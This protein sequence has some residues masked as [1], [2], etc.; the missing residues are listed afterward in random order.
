MPRKK[1]IPINRSAHRFEAQLFNRPT[2]DIEHSEDENDFQSGDTIDDIDRNLNKKHKISGSC[3]SS[4]WIPGCCSR[5]CTSKAKSIQTLVSDFESDA[6]YVHL[7]SFNIS[8]S[9][10]L[11]S[12][13]SLTLALL[14]SALLLMNSGATIAHFHFPALVGAALV[15]LKLSLCCY[16]SICRNSFSANLFVHI[17]APVPPALLVWCK[18]TRFTNFPWYGDSTI[19]SLNSNAFLSS[20]STMWK[21]GSREEVQSIAHELL[22]AGVETNL[23]QYQL[24][25][26]HWM[27]HKL[28]SRSSTTILQTIPLSGWVMITKLPDVYYSEVLKS[29]WKQTSPTAA[30]DSYSFPACVLADEMGIG[31]SLQVISLILLL[32]TR[33]ERGLFMEKIGL[34]EDSHIKITTFHL[35]RKNAMNGSSHRQRRRSAIIAE[36]GVLTPCICGRGE[37]EKDDVGWVNCSV[38]NRPRHLRCAGLST[39]TSEYQCLSCTS[40]YY[41]HHPIPSKTVLIIIPSTLTNQW[42]NEI[43]KH[44]NRNLSLKVGLYRGKKNPSDIAKLTPEFLSTFDIIFIS[45]KALRSCFYEAELDWT[46]TSNVSRRYDVF[47]PSLLGIEFRLVVIDETQNIEGATENMIFK[48][49][50]KLRTRR[51]LSVSG[52]PFGVGTIRDLLH[53]AQFLRISPLNGD[54]QLFNQWANFFEKPVLPISIETRVQWLREL[55]YPFILRRTKDMIR[56]QL[57]ISERFTLVRNLAMSEFEKKLYSDSVQAIHNEL[58]AKKLNDNFQALGK[59]KIELIRKACCHPRIF[60]PSLQIGKAGSASSI[61]KIMVM[62]VEQTKIRCEEAQRD[63]LFYLFK[64]AG[65]RLLQAQ[66]CSIW[67]ET[68]QYIYAAA[69]VYQLALR[70]IDKNRSSLTSF[71]LCQLVGDESFDE[72]HVVAPC[73]SSLL[74]TWTISEINFAVNNSLSENET[75]VKWSHSIPVDAQDKFILEMRDSNISTASISTDWFPSV[76]LGL[77]HKK[78]IISATISPESVWKIEEFCKQQLRMET[79]KQSLVVLFPAEYSLAASDFQDSFVTAV[80]YKTSS[81]L[82]YFSTSLDSIDRS[83]STILYQ[84]SRTFRAK[85][86]KINVSRCHSLVL[87]LQRDQNTITEH[88][89]W[90]FSWCPFNELNVCCRNPFSTTVKMWANF[91]ISETQFDTDML[92]ELHVQYNLRHT[93][94]D[95]EERQLPMVLPSVESASQLSSLPIISS[96]TPVANIEDSS[97][98]HSLLQK[99]ESRKLLIETEVRLYFD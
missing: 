88:E 50:M 5:I 53:L 2:S 54:D 1:S 34:E 87:V 78:S 77:I 80:S 9:T 21:I 61:D 99:A 89:Q 81:P 60:D 43:R 19:L 74:F 96:V 46:S 72:S 86:W 48:M 97:M 73:F 68:N 17:N 20:F 11:I 95:L 49:A 66:S 40:T 39:A 7:S 67:D 51:K 13:S 42:L 62:K 64:L 36:S 79:Q 93:L 71:L 8:L 4:Q 85:Q 28:A 59:S 14:P 56:E 82:S 70:H 15:K 45:F 41:F 24:E 58:L 35:K 3:P 6:N 75:M 10:E 31:K 63:L 23:R 55:F 47:P 32:R 69:S 16:L 26:I 25:G 33:F 37:L 83:Q 12:P 38:C 91:A 29:F 52:T 94:L 84:A 27:W 90:Q 92:Q 22:S 98:A 65:I 44:V 18:S 57:G 76:K 30:V